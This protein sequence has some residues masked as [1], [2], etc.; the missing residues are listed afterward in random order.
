MELK[1]VVQFEVEKET[2]KY[3]LHIPEGAP[4]GEVYTV[5]AEL[6]DRVLS[7]INEH[8]AKRAEAE[9]KARADAEAAQKPEIRDVVAE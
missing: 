5:V 3:R 1:N 7:I 6:L 9:A 2:R 8:A 4:L